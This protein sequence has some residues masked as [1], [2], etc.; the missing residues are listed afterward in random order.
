MV[1]AYCEMIR[2]YEEI[3]AAM[4]RAQWRPLSDDSVCMKI[5]VSAHAKHYM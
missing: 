3:N 2:I 4:N 1:E 5:H